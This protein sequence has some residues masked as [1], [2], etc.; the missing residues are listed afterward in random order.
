MPTPTRTALL[1][2][3]MALAAVPAFAAD[4]PYFRFRSLQPDK[5]PQP[6]QANG[7]AGEMPSLS[8]RQGRSVSHGPA[9]GS[10]GTAPYSWTLQSGPLPTG[11][12]LGSDGILT[13][14]AAA[15]G[16]WPGIVLA[17]SDADGKTGLSNA[18]SVSVLPSPSLSYRTVR[19]QPGRQVAIP[20]QP[21]NLVGTPSYALTSG[22]LPT[23]LRLDADGV[24]RGALPTVAGSGPLAV[25]L[26]DSD[27]EP[28]TSP[29][30]SV[31]AAAT[32]PLLTGRDLDLS[33]GQDFL[34]AA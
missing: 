32:N 23:G 26:R 18:F 22:S 11:T 7:L 29:A 5:A 19:V 1:A 14:V 20:P 3:A 12:T 15:A 28:A 27:G 10:G 31:E 6:G 13:G 30:F 9:R 4:S 17:L 24:I 16:T 25:T 2:F 8:V 34:R 33:M 21:S